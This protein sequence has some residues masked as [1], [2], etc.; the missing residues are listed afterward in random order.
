MKR[1]RSEKELSHASMARN[2]A[3]KGFDVGAAFDVD[4]S[5]DFFNAAFDG[6]VPEVV[7]LLADAR[8]DVNIL[9]SQTQSSLMVAAYFGHL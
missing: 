3:A 8:V 5:V 7:A 1:N 4:K 9:D 2:M 6:D